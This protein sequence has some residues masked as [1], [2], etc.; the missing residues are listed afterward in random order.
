[1][2]ATLMEKYNQPYSEII[3]M[4]INDAIFFVELASAE[5]KKESTEIKKMEK[6]MK[7]GSR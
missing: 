2:I 1:M 7:K 6:N 5:Y 4:P 3:N